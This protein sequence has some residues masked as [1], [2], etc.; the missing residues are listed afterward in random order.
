MDHTHTLCYCLTSIHFTLVH[1]LLDVVFII[2]AFLTFVCM[3]F[4][5]VCDEED[6]RCGV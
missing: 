3:F 5:S 6:Y 1:V 2:C 4:F